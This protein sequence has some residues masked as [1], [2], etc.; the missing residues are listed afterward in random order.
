M[1][2]LAWTP[3]Q[4]GNL[5][6]DSQHVQL[7]EAQRLGFVYIYRR[8]VGDWREFW[9]RSDTYSGSDESNNNGDFKTV[10][11]RT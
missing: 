1:Q 7:K 11:A 9:S 5:Q 8:G 2:V 4:L 10:A 3:Q 6:T